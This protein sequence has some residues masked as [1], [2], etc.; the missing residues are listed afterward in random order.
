VGVAPNTLVSFPNNTD[1]GRVTALSVVLLTTSRQIELNLSLSNRFL[2]TTALQKFLPRLF[3]VALS[4]LILACEDSGPTVRGSGPVVTRTL[5]LDDIRGLAVSG[6]QNVVVTQGS[7][8]EIVV[9]GQANLIDILSTRVRDG[10]WEV[11]FTENTRSTEDFTVFVTVPDVDQINVS[12]S[13]NV[14]G[15]GDLVLD[16][17]SVTVSGSGN[18]SLAGTV[19]EQTAIVSGSGKVSNYSMS[20][21]Q[22]TATVSGSGAVRVTATETLNATV[23]GSGDI[24]YRGNPAAVTRSISG[25]GQVSA[26]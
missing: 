21:R 5:D 19:D 9:E 7:P 13:G 1:K 12:G 26:G 24:S 20:S 6:S 8:Q 3:I 4:V 18:V 15:N 22:T 2:M 11:R 16:E 10:I 23:S 14:S 17:L 25:S